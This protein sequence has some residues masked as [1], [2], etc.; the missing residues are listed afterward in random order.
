MQLT[1]L[2]TAL[3]AAGQLANALPTPGPELASSS[4]AERQLNYQNFYFC[5]RDAE[6]PW[7]RSPCLPEDAAATEAEKRDVEKRFAEA[8]ADA[9]ASLAQL[10]KDLESELASALSG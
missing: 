8:T 9:E 3:A 5:P 2:I 7:K 1:H 4:L 10:K 6:G